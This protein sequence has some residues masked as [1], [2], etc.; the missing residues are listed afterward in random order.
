MKQFLAFI[1]CVLALSISAQDTQIRKG[2]GG[3]GGSATNA[4]ATI[5]KDGT[6]IVNGATVID[7]TNAAGS[8]VT[9][10]ADGTT[11]RV[12]IPQGGALPS[13]VLTNA[14][15][16]T[17]EFTSRITNSSS[18]GGGFWSADSIGFISLSSATD[19][20]LMSQPQGG[21]LATLD[22]WILGD[23]NS[24]KTILSLSTNTSFFPSN[25]WVQGTNLV[26]QMTFTG[27]QPSNSFLYLNAQ[28]NVA[29]GTFGSGLSFSGGTLTSSGGAAD[30]GDITLITNTAGTV[31][32]PMTT[33][34]LVMK[35][36]V[37]PVAGASQIILQNGTIG[38][39]FTGVYFGDTVGSTNLGF[40][41]ILVNDSNL[42][43]V[44]EI[45]VNRNYLD[46]GNYVQ[47]PK[48]EKVLIHG[49]YVLSTNGVNTNLLLWTSTTLSNNNITLAGVTNLRSFGGF[50]VKG[51][52]YTNASFIQNFQFFNSL[53]Q[54]KMFSYRA[55]NY[56]SSDITMTLHT[57]SVAANMYDVRSKTNVNTIT[58]P[59]SSV[60]TFDLDWTGNGFDIVNL[61]GV[62]YTLAAGYK[63]ELITNGLTITAQS[64]QR[65]TNY[66]D[67]TTIIINAGTDVTAN[68]TNAVAGNRTIAFA[69]P[70]IGMSGSLGFVSDASARTLTILSTNCLITWMSTNNTANSTNILTDASKRSIFA[71]RVGMGTDG[72]ST[73]IHCWVKNQTP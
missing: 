48:N 17:V 29:A 54:Q 4:V 16:R 26:R 57:N 65:Y 9:V 46:D 42:P 43:Q 73:N 60:T 70:V 11:A 24:T 19:Y 49:L 45:W 21:I 56:G 37:T 3:A 47:I 31:T 71:W 62:Q 12:G 38:K 51:L 22:G 40:H 20:I 1:F 18:S 10:T 23:A 35:T 59:A 28:S 67:A 53:P 36:N 6:P 5:R 25:L 15:T 8:V 14:D 2:G 39:S 61:E 41:S 34:W 55:T 68:I 72:V 50:T 13:Y 63:T 33:N 52:Q 44:D 64:T 30:G 69:T 32:L 66:A 27:G 58:L 7:F